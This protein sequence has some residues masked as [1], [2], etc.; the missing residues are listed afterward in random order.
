MTAGAPATRS[1]RARVAA[2]GLL[3]EGRPLAVAVSG[4]RDSLCLLGLAVELAG[5][6]AVVAVHVH[7]GLRGASA[8]HDAARVSAL[9]GE[10]GVA[11][12]VLRLTPPEA[13]AE[14]A[15]SP[16]VWARDGRRAALRAA[17]DRWA[18]PGTPVAVGHTASDQAETVL[19][20]AIS[21][22]G[23]RALAG[24]AP[25]DAARHVVRPLL[26]AGLTR[27]DT[28]SWCVAHGLA[29]HDDPTNPETPRGRVREL[30]RGL[31]R[32]DP[33]ATGALVATAARAR[34]DDAALRTLAAAMLQPGDRSAG[35]PPWLDAAALGAAPTAVARRALRGLA[36]ASLDRRCPRV[37]SRLADVL[38][39]RPTPARP[40]ALDLGDGVRVVVSADPEAR[41]RC[42]P[43]PVRA[44]ERG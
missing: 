3:P 17:A 18:G 10:L 23:S 14:G 31:E 30:L 19:L 34:E 20:R 25:R 29:W 32:I 37:A 38:A 36:E 5:A 33:R 15:G 35:E 44:R 1:L 12:R 42:E 8:D 13:V 43:S 26:A 28:G 41:V 16:A 2:T 9:A 6:D 22:P 11:V 39:L 7:H 21:S 27:E 24:I 40:A 4:G